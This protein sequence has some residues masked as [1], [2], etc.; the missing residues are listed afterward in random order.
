MKTK[1]NKVDVMV[2]PMGLYKKYYHVKFHILYLVI[3]HTNL[4]K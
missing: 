1:G 4:Q 3:V 2:T